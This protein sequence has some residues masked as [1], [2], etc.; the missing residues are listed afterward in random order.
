MDAAGTPTGT[1]KCAVPSLELHL[2][3]PEEL[4]G[5]IPIRVS[6]QQLGA[7]GYVECATFWVLCVTDGPMESS[8]PDSSEV[9][10]LEHLAQLPPLERFQNADRVHVRGLAAPI[11]RDVGVALLVRVELPRV[12]SYIHIAIAS[13]KMFRF[14]ERDTR[15]F[16]WK[17]RSK[18]IVSL[19]GHVEAN[20]SFSSRG[21]FVIGPLPQECYRRPVPSATGEGFRRR[22][23]TIA[24]VGCAG[25]QHRY[26]TCSR[27]RLI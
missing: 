15:R 21:R 6:G 20:A 4:A 9:V 5:A 8:L 13:R 24:P 2:I 11:R 7:E 1:P 23:A 10:R 18:T 19:S 27:S 17:S 14:S 22:R 3:E 16:G 25:P 12:G 26:Q